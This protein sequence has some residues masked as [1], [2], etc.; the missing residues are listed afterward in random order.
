MSPFDEDPANNRSELDLCIDE[1]KILKERNE[2]LEQLLI[3]Y[4]VGKNPSE[5]L[6][7]MLDRTKQALEGGD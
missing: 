2:A 6:H 3:C 1:I 7:K 4:R 5:K